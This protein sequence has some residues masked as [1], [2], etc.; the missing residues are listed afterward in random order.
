MF[1]NI[2]ILFSEKQIATNTEKECYVIRNIVVA[3]RP[4]FNLSPKGCV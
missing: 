1:I 3:N 4:S 2:L